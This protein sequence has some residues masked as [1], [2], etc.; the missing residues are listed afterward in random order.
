M[1]SW[2]IRSLLSLRLSFSMLLAFNQLGSIHTPPTERSLRAQEALNCSDLDLATSCGQYPFPTKQI[3][4]QRFLWIVE[5]KRPNSIHMSKKGSLSG[6]DFHSDYHQKARPDW[7]DPNVS[8]TQRLFE[9]FN[10]F[11]K[12]TCQSCSY[13]VERLNGYISSK[14]E[15]MCLRTSLVSSLSSLWNLRLCSYQG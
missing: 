4:V 10:I 8:I 14:R 3:E 1:Q 5:S 2:T 13:W 11:S 12:W 6:R 15:L 9:P 7:T